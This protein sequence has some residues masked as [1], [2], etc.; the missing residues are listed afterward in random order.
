MSAQFYTGPF[1]YTGNKRRLMPQLAPHLPEA[2]TYI[3][4]FAGSGT[5][6]LNAPAQHVHFNDTNADNIE[7]L[8]YLAH[9]PAQDVERATDNLIAHY[10]LPQAKAELMTPA[11]QHAYNRL[12]D[13]YNN[14]PTVEKYYALI[15]HCFNNQA[16]KNAKGKFNQTGGH[17]GFHT[18]ARQKL[19]EYH[20][21][22]QQI[23]ATFSI[24]DF[25]T[26]NTGTHPDTVVYADPPY[27]GTD[28]PYQLRSA[29]TGTDERDLYEYLDD[30]HQ[31]GQRFIVSNVFAMKGTENT[32]LKT[33]AQKYNVHHLAMTYATANHGYKHRNDKVDEVAITNFDNDPALTLF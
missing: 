4:L 25:R 20:A 33:W 9:T 15:L 26:V 18:Q 19:Y 11:G 14:A 3:D 5:V 16:R 28:T 6:G 21:R 13:D 7:L 31:R 29:W 10:N 8:K 2:T 32:I 12:R 27:L 24:G 23:S 22:A 17:R 30:V 1:T